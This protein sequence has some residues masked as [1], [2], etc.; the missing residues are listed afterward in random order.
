MTEGMVWTSPV[1]VA[2]PAK[3]EAACSVP[4]KLSHKRSVPWTKA[5]QQWG[6]QVPGGEQGVRVNINTE[7]G[8]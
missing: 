6:A 4:G 8:S 2:T 5:G 7:I 1:Q 3:S